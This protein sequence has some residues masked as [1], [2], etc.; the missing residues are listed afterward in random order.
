[1]EGCNQ[2]GVTDERK[3][4]S[5]NKGVKGMRE[6]SQLIARCDGY[7]GDVRRCGKV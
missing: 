4:D 2:E 5:P 6:V 1:M 7:E 3:Y